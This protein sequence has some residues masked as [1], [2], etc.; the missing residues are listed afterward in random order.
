VSPDLLWDPDGAGYKVVS[1]TVSSRA[2]ATS[3]DFAASTDADYL[4]AVFL[5]RSTFALVEMVRLPWPT[6]L[7]LGKVTDD[8]VL[9]RWSRTSPVF[10][11]AERL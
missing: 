5:S 2:Q 4:L 11:A 6:V 10:E 3:F 9:L 1:R 8:R 7:W